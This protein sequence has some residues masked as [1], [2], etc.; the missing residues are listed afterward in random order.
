MLEG[1]EGLT[2]KGQ[3]KTFWGDENVLCLDCGGSY[4]RVVEEVNFYL[5]PLKDFWLDLR[6]KFM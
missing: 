4:I 2:A 5:Y 6:I 1:Q 3:K